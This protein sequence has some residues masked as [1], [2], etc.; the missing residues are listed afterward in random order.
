M[1]TATL[2]KFNPPQKKLSISIRF[3]IGATISIGQEIQF[4]PYAGFFVNGYKFS[5][6]NELIFRRWNTL[7]LFSVS[8]SL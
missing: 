8:N 4:L 3:G 7:L 1:L 2:K 5:G 6:P